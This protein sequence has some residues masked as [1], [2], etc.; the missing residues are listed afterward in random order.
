MKV[1]QAVKPTQIEIWKDVPNPSLDEK[2]VLIGNRPLFGTNVGLIADIDIEFEG[3][4]EFRER[5]SALAYCDADIQ[6][7]GLEASFNMLQWTA[8]GLE[9]ALHA[10]QYPN[11]LVRWGNKQILS[12]S[13]IAFILTFAPGVY[14]YMLIYKTLVT[15]LP[16][17]SPSKKKF[18]E[19]QVNLTAFEYEDYNYELFQTWA[20][21]GYHVLESFI[22]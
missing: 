18:L 2:L 12:F 22:L 14:G 5:H 13:S 20:P 21:D 15:K 6:S 7:Y 17:I 10:K 16:K 3:K 8:E 9:W 1:S 11:G 4:F 19:Q